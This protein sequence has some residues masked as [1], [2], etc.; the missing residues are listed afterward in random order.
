MHAGRE[1]MQIISYLSETDETFA[2]TELPEKASQKD[3]TNSAVSFC[4]VKLWR[5]EYQKRKT[6]RMSRPI[7]KVTSPVGSSA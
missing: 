5:A 2:E 3:T 4:S 6:L 1:S 7:C